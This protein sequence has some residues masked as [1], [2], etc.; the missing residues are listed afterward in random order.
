MNKILII[1]STV[2]G[3]TELVVKKVSQILSEN[4]FVVT[5]KRV[6]IAMPDEILDN[7]L[8]I[9]ASPTYNQ[10]TLEDKFKPF[11][12]NWKSIDT[13]NKEFAVIGLG[14]TK[15]YPEYLTE[16]SDIL[17]EMVKKNGR[18]F[19]PALRIGIDPLKVLNS[20]V[21]KW[22]DKLVQKLK[23]NPNKI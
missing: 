8:T 17:E 23:N 13:G 11:I 6:D 12:K 3:N 18:L 22:T 15:Y 2:G 4:N 9:L 21:S 1:Y 16:S 7:D 5:I 10:G 19:S 14:H 20:L